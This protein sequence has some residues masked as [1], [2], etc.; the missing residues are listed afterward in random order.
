MKLSIIVNDSLTFGL[1]MNAAAVL[2]LSIGN[3]VPAAAVKKLTGNLE[4]YR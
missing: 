3:Q 1:A 4:L 2:G